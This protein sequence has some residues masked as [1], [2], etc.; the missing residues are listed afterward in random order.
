M[1]EE[2]IRTKAERVF[3]HDLKQPLAIA[4]GQARLLVLGLT[5][6]D[7]VKLPPEKVIEKVEKILTA[8]DELNSMIGARHSQ[9]MQTEANGP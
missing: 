6:E 5:R 2:S 8:L 7:G 9:L 3:L 4:H 1:S